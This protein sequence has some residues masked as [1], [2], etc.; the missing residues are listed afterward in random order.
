MRIRMLTISLLALLGAFGF[1]PDA[2]AQGSAHTRLL[3]RGGTVRPELQQMLRLMQSKGTLFPKSHTTTQTS[4]PLARRS[5]AK[6]SRNLLGGGGSI[7]GHISGITDAAT[8]PSV[9]AYTEDRNNGM[10][11]VPGEVERTGDY[12]IEGLDAGD[13]VVLIQAE[14]CVTKFYDNVSTPDSATMVRVSGSS[15]TR[16]IDFTMERRP[17]GTGSISG[18]VRAEW[19]NTP[20]AGATVVAFGTDNSFETFQGV[21]EDD[22]SYRIDGLSS[23][24]YMV[25]AI[26][27][28]YFPEYYR[29]APTPDQAT[30]ITV[31]EPGNVSGAD[32][33]L[34]KGATISGRVLDGNGNPLANVFVE[35]IQSRPS[36]PNDSVQCGYGVGVTDENGDYEISALY[37]GDYLVSASVWTERF[38]MTLWYDGATDFTT[39][40]HVPV[41]V[42]NPATGIDFNMTLP[43]GNGSIAG[44][45]LDGSGNPVEGASII[46]MADRSSGISL[47]AQAMTAADGTYRIDSLPDGSFIVGAFASSGW[48]SVSIYWRDAVLEEDADPVVLQGGR[49]LAGS[50]D[51]NLPLAVGSASISG[52]VHRADGSPLANAFVMVIP[53]SP[54]CG[55]IPFFGDMAM[56]DDNGA[57]SISGLPEGSY[58]AY[59]AYWEN[60]SYDDQWYLNAEVPESATE[61]PLGATDSRTDIDFTL[62]P[63]PYYG[64]ISGRV[65]DDATGQPIAGANIQIS[66][67]FDGNDPF[68]SFGDM[69]VIT[70]DNG[71]YT[72]E[73][74]GEG[75]YMV[76]VIANGSFEIYENATSPERATLVDV[77]GGESTT[78]S[79]G[80]SPRNEGNGSITGV[81]TD[82][83]GSAIGS[84]VI[85]A[86][87]ENDPSALPFTAISA[88]DGSYRIGGMPAGRYYVL[89]FARGYIGEYFRNAYDASEATLADVS[90]NGNV[91][92]VDFDLAA[93][94][95]F[96]DGGTPGGM[97][98][99]G[100]IRGTVADVE[101][102]G[103][104]GATVHLINGSGQAIA[105]V[106]SGADGRY[107]LVGL[108]NGSEYR[109]MASSP[110]FDSR[111][112]NE[113][114]RFEEAAPLAVG[115]GRAVD[116]NFT[117]S[118]GTSSVP[119]GNG[120]IAGLELKGNHPNPFT[121]GTSIE[122]AL[123][124][125][126][127]VTLTVLDIA[128]REIVRLHDGRM[129][130]GEHSIRWNGTTADGAAAA[131][132]VYIYRVDVDGKTTTG[133]MILAR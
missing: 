49:C 98:N 125:P 86:L 8:M 103:I 129:S 13:Y 28:G 104:V 115:L 90:D 37:D 127:H 11:V 78:V 59:A 61:I 55:G 81:V 56:T 36:D 130:A 101:G 24:T 76:S 112:N 105:S 2:A 57:Y 126:G 107:E 67:V 123:A 118:A 20:L 47:F 63:R 113:A 69:A 88:A 111:Y 41:S 95:C 52:T 109:V 23:G 48:Q 44:T 19:T 89:G 31:V 80:L 60:E 10:I 120:S 32:F 51:F 53:T 38:G 66:P 124:E 84:A 15:T 131:N 62:S 122:L 54:V 79:F 22:G 50:V 82:E 110:G 99:G 6:G 91:A 68:F 29:N 30:A 5:D 83:S 43:V 74:L 72:A 102:N 45:V 108:P 3:M 26:A 97:R 73:Y 71:E 39:A 4:S 42:G 121:S 96:P 85:L 21:V 75:R 92:G 35:A 70:D 27:E 9:L 14:G 116:V 16:G 100:T 7:T 117:L 65:T 18:S 106:R 133:R 93:N 40:T 1:L 64:T 17:V 46:V 132:G 58:L 25:A 12:A 119:A 33:L 114:R 87:P 94:V 34:S 128:G 77:V